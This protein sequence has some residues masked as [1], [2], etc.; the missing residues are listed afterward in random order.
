MKEGEAGKTPSKYEPK[1]GTKTRVQNLVRHKSGR[2]YARLYEGGKERWISLKTD[3][4]GVAQ[5][6][7]AEHIQGHKERRAA[8][9]AAGSGKMTFGQ[10]LTLQPAAYRAG[11]LQTEHRP[12]L[13]PDD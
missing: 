6:K 13:E 10:A 8:K 4:F 11:R 7:L 1:T 5:A 3:H 9:S 12:V 2:Y